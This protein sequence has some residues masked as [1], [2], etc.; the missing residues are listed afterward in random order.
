MKTYKYLVLAFTIFFFSLDAMQINEKASTE[1]NE[2]HKDLDLKAAMITKNRIYQLFKAISKNPKKANKEKL[3]DAFMENVKDL[4]ALA[5][6][7]FVSGA[8]IGGFSLLLTD[9]SFDIGPLINNRIV[10]N[11]IGKKIVDDTAASLITTALLGI[12]C[13][14]IIVRTAVVLESTVKYAAANFLGI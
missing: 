5:L 10:T 7:K 1:K 8:F 6:S 3:N 4:A 2:A 9:I 11:V 12:S 14:P 13:I